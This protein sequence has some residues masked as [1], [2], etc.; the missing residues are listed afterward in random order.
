MKRASPLNFALADYSRGL[1]STNGTIC[2]ASCSSI[3]WKKRPRKNSNPTSTRSNTRPK[4][5]WRQP[6][7]NYQVVKLDEPL[8]SAI[9]YQKAIMIEDTVSHIEEKI[10]A[11]DSIKDDR[12][13]ELLQLLGTLKSEIATLS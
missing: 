8:L 1:S 7:N 3:A 2:K 6:R 11:S 9:L 5:N 13:R 4:P 12:K 10:Q